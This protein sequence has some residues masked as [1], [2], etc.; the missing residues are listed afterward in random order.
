MF[1]H[2]SSPLSVNATRRELNARQAET[3]ERVAAAAQEELRVVGF[4]EM[5]IRSVASRAA[6]APAT[7]YTYFSSKNH[8]VAEIFWRRLSERPHL[9]ARKT[10]P[11]ERVSAVFED[12]AEFLAAE[13]ELAAATSA[14]LLGAEPDVKHLQVMIGVEINT[15]IEN[16]L[17]PD[18]LDDVKDA[19][20]LA[21][22]GAMLQAG[23]GHAH[24]EQM[25]ERLSR[26][27]AL[28]LGGA[29]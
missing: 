1:G 20:S 8:L 19:L 24:F 29:A 7:A 12:L 15:R 26:V 10:S 21:W 13:P 17:G 5:T 9:E 22:A 28:L 23:Q 16:A 14:A 25:G 18:V 4:D 3:V 2:V 6:V 27:A 11:L